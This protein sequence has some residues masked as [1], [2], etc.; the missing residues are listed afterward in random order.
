[1]LDEVNRIFHVDLSEKTH[2]HFVKLQWFL[3]LLS[4]FSGGKVYQED[5]E[6]ASHNEIVVVV[7]A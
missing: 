1:M 6:Q 4:V 2:W 5:G 3:M 7:V